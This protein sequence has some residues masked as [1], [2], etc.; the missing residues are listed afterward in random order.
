MIVYFPFCSLFLWIKPYFAGSWARCIDWVTSLPLPGKQA[1]SYSFWAVSN[2]LAQV[3]CT[4]DQASRWNAEVGS[5]CP[6]LPSES[7][8]HLH[9]AEANL[10]HPAVTG[11][12]PFFP[13]PISWP[14]S[15]STCYFLSVD[16]RCG[17]SSFW[18][19]ALSS[20]DLSFPW[21]I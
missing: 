9:S 10:V 8:Y 16:I 17:P 12:H 15:A 7:G 6:L 1:V 11:L 21:Y 3:L 19:K 18:R 14:A 2:G 20:V 4:F 13:S 5:P